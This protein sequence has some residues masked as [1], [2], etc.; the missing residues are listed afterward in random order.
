VVVSQQQAQGGLMM[1]GLHHS[2][3]QPNMM[4]APNNMYNQA[5]TPNMYNT[6]VAQQ[7]QQHQ[8]QPMHQLQN[9]MAGMNL[10]GYQQPT[11]AMTNGGWGNQPSGQTLSNNLWQ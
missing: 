9:Q 5:A 4:M 7:Q 1:G 2:M 6:P 11:G 8:Q 10:A 3:S